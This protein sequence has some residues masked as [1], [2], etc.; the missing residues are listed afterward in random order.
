MSLLPGVSAVAGS[1]RAIIRFGHLVAAVLA[2][3]LVD[4]SGPPSWGSSPHRGGPS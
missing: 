3:A 2:V 4:P 1:R